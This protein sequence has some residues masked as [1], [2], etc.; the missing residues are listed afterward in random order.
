MK[1]IYLGNKQ[2]KNNPKDFV[3]TVNILLALVK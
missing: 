3:N 1:M 2:T